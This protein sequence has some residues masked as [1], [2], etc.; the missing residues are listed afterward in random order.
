MIIGFVM[1]FTQ[2]HLGKLKK[3]M[4]EKVPNSCLVNSFFFGK[5]QEV[6]ISQ[7][8]WLHVHALPESW[9]NLFVQ[10]QGKNVA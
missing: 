2:G 9:P 6:L 1:I 7:K 4:K 3:T 10:V 5:I 8:D